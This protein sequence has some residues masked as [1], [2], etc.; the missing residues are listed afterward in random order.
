MSTSSEFIAAAKRDARVIAALIR[1]LH[2]MRMVNG[3]MVDVDGVKGCLNFEADI[4]S[5]KSALR[6]LNIDTDVP[7]PEPIRRRRG[8][9]GAG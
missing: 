3:L 1:A 5:L 9:R 6:L 8:E 7:L 4:A 2:S